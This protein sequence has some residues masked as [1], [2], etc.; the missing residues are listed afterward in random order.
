MILA[1]KNVITKSGINYMTEEVSSMPKQAVILCAG[2]ATRL[3]P[4]TAKVPKALLP[5][6]GK[7]LLWHIIHSLKDH[8]FK[9]FFINLHHFP[10]AIKNCL[11]GGSKLGVKIEY[12]CEKEI[13]GTAGGLK[14]FEKDLDDAFL[15][16]YGDLFSKFDYSKFS[17]F[18][19]AKK[20]CLGVQ[21]IGPTDHPFDSD[22]V[23]TDKENRFIKIHKKP[24]QSLPAAHSS[25]FGIYLFSKRIL[26]YIPE[27]QYYEIDHHLLPS[28]LERGEG[29]FGYGLREGEYVHDI[30]T[31]ER[32]KGLKVLKSWI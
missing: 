19:L 29:Y 32:Y 22:L 30:G 2:F 16:N 1:S 9:E 3:R 5:V 20:P 7:P 14:T 13:L 8:G 18:Y 15:V 31:H 21:V 11:G 26:N 25:M 6:F 28:V 4:L 17:K 12:S 23:E 24:H 10:D 27:N